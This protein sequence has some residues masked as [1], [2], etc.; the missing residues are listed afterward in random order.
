MLCVYLPRRR[1]IGCTQKNNYVQE[2]RCYRCKGNSFIRWLYEQFLS[3]SI[4]TVILWLNRQADSLATRKVSPLVKETASYTGYR[5]NFICQLLMQFHSL[6]TGTASF[7][8]YTNNFIQQLRDLELFHYLAIETYHSLAT[9][10]V[11]FTSH[12]ISFIHQLKDISYM[13]TLSE[14]FH[15]L[16]PGSISITRHR[17]SFIRQLPKQFHLLQ[18]QEQF[19]SFCYMNSLTH[20]EELHLLAIGTVSHMVYL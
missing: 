9:G 2:Q 20:T 4:G 10:T 11:S 5:N 13:Y 18:L 15:L 14:H 6:A 8:S 12:V 16:V 7:T 19:Y 1:N 3:L 17:N